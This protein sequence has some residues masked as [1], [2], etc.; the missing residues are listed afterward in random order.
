MVMPSFRPTPSLPPDA[1]S[2]TAPLTAEAVRP[3]I[4]D[5][6]RL[7]HFFVGPHLELEG[8]PPVVET[9]PWEL[10]QGRL[11]DPAFTRVRRSFETWN[12]F[13]VEGG[14]RSAEPVLSVK[15]DAGAGQVQVVRALP[16]YAWEG[17]DA[18][19]GVY[20]SR[21][22]R[23]WVR[24]LVGT[25]PLARLSS[26][27]EFLDELVC[28]LFLA[29][30]GTSRL[31][32]TSLEAPLP[33]FALGQLAY[34]YRPG[35]GASGDQPMRSYQ[36]LAALP[37]Q[38]DLASVERAKLLETLL[39]ATPVAEL[40]KMAAL[41]FR[42][43]DTPTDLLQ[44]LF[45]EVSLSPYTD[46]VEKTLA[47][48][49]VLEDQGTVSPAETVD[50][51]ARLLRQIGR[52]LSAYDLVTFHQRGA[53]Y[54]DALLLHAV[55][56]AYLDLARRRPDLFRAPPGTAE[57]GQPERRLRRRALRQAWL[58]RSWYEG[59]PVPDAPTS[60]GEALRVLPEPFVRVP[61][62]QILQ[63]TRRRR[64]LFADDPLAARRTGDVAELLTETLCDLEYPDE[65]RELGMA[66]FLDRPLG[67]GKAATEPDATP[68]LSYEAFSPSLAERRLQYLADQLGLLAPA[69]LAASRQQLRA[70][71]GVRGIPTSAVPASPRPGV[72]SLADARQ[73]APD[74]VLLRT[75]ARSARAFLRVYDFGPLRKRFHL[76]WLGAGPP[77]LILGAG[78]VGPL[79]A[80]TFHDAELRPRLELA[81]DP[82]AGY[83]SRAG[84]DFPASGLQVLRVWEDGAI[85]GSLQ[86]HD[87]G[88]EG[89]VVQVSG[90][91]PA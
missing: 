3:V 57:D 48:L 27:E 42:P 51:L 16:C 18:G 70:G 63:P 30:V 33:A 2:G 22:T 36:E 44:T 47:L 54:P 43:G 72:V 50:F 79:A 40:G 7:A 78:R 76:S 12:V 80:V 65:L 60:Q 53:N 58:L 66:L 84:V 74:F 83:A 21:E 75:T 39:H 64:R 41:F 5:T 24:E 23:K 55:L 32:L 19:G 20:L 86:E 14:V 91:R 89:L 35:A 13:L 10:F 46:L 31:P 52:H 8:G 1:A 15:L 37:D 56:R 25:I 6:V 62:E 68:L 29:V 90:S 73:A 59:L 49:G 38:A 82:S 17:Y 67:V 34:C 11:L 77:L 87:V 4:T 26:A 85:P 71:L 69:D 88:R 28:L 81:F 61:E 9:V 45:N